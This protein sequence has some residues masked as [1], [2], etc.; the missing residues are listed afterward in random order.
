VTSFFGIKDAYFAFF[1]K[2]TRRICDKFFQGLG[3]NICSL[4]P[5]L[6]SNAPGLKG[7]GQDP[8][9]EYNTLLFVSI[10]SILLCYIVLGNDV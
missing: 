6:K 3:E 1:S 5:A 4:Q 8:P 10:T 2:T 9:S 7:T